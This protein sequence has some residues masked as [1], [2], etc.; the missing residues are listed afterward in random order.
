MLTHPK[1]DADMPPEPANH[2]QHSA[3]Y[4]VFG[5][6]I[7]HSKSPAIHAAFAQQCGD[8]VTYRAVSVELEAFEGKVLGFFERGGCGLNITVPFKERAFAMA[9]EA[10]D[11]AA[12]A[13]AANCLIPL[14]DGRIRADNTDGIGMVRDMVANHG[15]QLDGRKTLI[16]GAGGAVRGIMHPLLQERPGSVFIANRTTLRAEA[17]AAEFSDLGVAV[18]GGGF[19]ALA[20]ET[21]DL[22]ING[23]SAGLAG[24]MPALPEFS[25]SE[26]CC[27][28]DMVYGAE[29]T[30]FMR[31]SAGKAAWAVAD[32][33]GMLVEQ[34]AESF[35]LWRGRRP[36]TREVIQQLRHMMEG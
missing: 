28:Y 20:G 2:P 12:R 6:P 21:F 30:P 19:E 25:L 9:H 8:D 33:L 27:C 26:R 29:P 22:I 13:K 10:S 16:L 18:S 34:A 24:E 17:L 14:G 4:A 5:N 32:G 36:A 35:Y 15:W 3:A 31:W 7:K 1:I 11:R 23:T